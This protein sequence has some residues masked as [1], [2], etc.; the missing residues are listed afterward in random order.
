MVTIAIDGPAASG[1]STIAKKLAKQLGYFYVDSGAMYRAVTYEWLEH[2]GGEK[3]EHDAEILQKLLQAFDLVF[4]GDTAI[5]NG[6]DISKE[7]RSNKV[8]QN[9][10][11]IASFP[12]VRDKLVEIQRKMAASKNIIMDGRDIGTVV[13]PQAELKIFMVA[14]AEVRAER[15]AKQLK[16]QGEE[17]NQEQLVQEIKLRDKLDSERKHAPLLKASDA[18]EINTDNLSINEVIDK[19]LDLC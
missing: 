16:E 2:A 6:K 12:I 11:Y 19:V 3:S 17:V 8:S 14:S 13:F 7:I 15:R 9:V 1:K 4:D 10:S 5:V 18:I